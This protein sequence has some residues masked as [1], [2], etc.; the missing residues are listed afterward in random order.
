MKLAREGYLF[1]RHLYEFT[2]DYAENG[3]MYT[4]PGYPHFVAVWKKYHDKYIKP[5]MD[6]DGV[7]EFTVETQQKQDKK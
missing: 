4:M 1:N 7:L 3:I 5:R 6:K 2:C